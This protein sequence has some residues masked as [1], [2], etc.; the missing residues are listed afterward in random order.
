[1]KVIT[2]SYEQEKDI[3][4]NVN[5]LTRINFNYPFRA[6]DHLNHGRSGS[7]SNARTAPP[8][9]GEEGGAIEA[10]GGGA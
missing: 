9:A 1:M 6:F 10:G 4:G 3:S 8:A 7:G 5:A 2:N